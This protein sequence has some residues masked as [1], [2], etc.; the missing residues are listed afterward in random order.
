MTAHK[1]RHTTQ[2]FALC[3]LSYD[4]LL[5]LCVC[6]VPPR[7]LIW[8]YILMITRFTGRL[9]KTDDTP[10]SSPRAR[11]CSRS[12]ATACSCGAGAHWTIGIK[13]TNINK[14]S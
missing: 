12:R 10:A 1:R 7:S 4:K 3:K 9:V 13:T 6:W 5:R 11:C 14:T 8:R 2:P